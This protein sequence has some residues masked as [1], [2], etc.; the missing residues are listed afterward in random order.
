[1]ALVHSREEQD[2]AAEVGEAEGGKEST[3]GREDKQINAVEVAKSEY[4]Q[5][6]V[7]D[8]QRERRQDQKQ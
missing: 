3:T 4:L 8:Q 1:M 2:G 5:S 6:R 7:V